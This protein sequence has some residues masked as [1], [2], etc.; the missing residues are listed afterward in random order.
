MHFAEEISTCAFSTAQCQGEKISPV[1]QS[2]IWET[3]PVS[4][5]QWKILFF[6]NVFLQYSSSRLGLFTWQMCRIAFTW[7]IFEALQ[8]KNRQTH[9][10]FYL[11]FLLLES[12]AGIS[13]WLLG[14]LRTSGRSLP[15]FAQVHF[16]I[17][18]ELKAASVFLEFFS[19]QVFLWVLSRRGEIRVAHIE[20][21]GG[22][23]TLGAL[24]TARICAGWKCFDL[25]QQAHREKIFRARSKKIQQ[26]LPR[27]WRPKSNK[28]IHG[29]RI[30][31]LLFTLCTKKVHERE[32]EGWFLFMRVLWERVVPSAYVSFAWRCCKSDLMASNNKNF[33]FP[34]LW[35]E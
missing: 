10:F 21:R 13:T 5:L 32:G 31:V 3:G 4:G 27:S 23:H 28:S 33:S 25:Y 35:H 14:I 6:L 8:A 30:G 11:S 24:L 22:G 29:K 12:P 7:R 26:T 18:K 34:C 9:N 15:L 2:I 19:S 17:Y 20:W 16:P 1:F